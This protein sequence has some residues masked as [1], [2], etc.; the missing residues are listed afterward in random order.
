LD[1]PRCGR[2]PEPDGAVSR[3]R[4]RARPPDFPSDSGTHPEGP[5]P[6]RETVLSDALDHAPARIL[7]RHRR[8]QDTGGGRGGRP[9]PGRAHA[10]RRPMT[11]RERADRRTGLL[12]LSPVLA[13]LGV[14]AIYP[15]VWVCWL[16]LQYRIPIFGI[17]RFAG[18][19]HYAFLATD[20]RFLN[21]TR[22]TLA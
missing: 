10:R 5:T 11:A 15:A 12:L 18:L 22:T 6:S 8:G 21:A 17:A 19:A 3:P 1:G 20:P 13:V 2:Q 14:V 16:S 7:G 4:N 9:P